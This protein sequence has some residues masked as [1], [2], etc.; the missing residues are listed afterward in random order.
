MANGAEL[1]MILRAEDKNT[2]SVF[3]SVAKE[4]QGMVAGVKSALSG[5]VAIDIMSGVKDG[6]SAIFGGALEAA[7]GVGRLQAQLGLTRQQAEDLGSVA[8]AVFRDG[9]GGSAG[10]VNAAV[11]TVRQNLGDLGSVVTQEMTQAAL[12]VKDLFGA[13]EAE[14]TRTVAVMTKNFQGLSE[15][16]AFDLITAGFQRGGDY[17]GELLDTLREYSPQFASMGM[18]AEQMM[19]VLIAGAQA[20]AFNLDKVG[21]AVKEFNIRAKDGSKATAEGFAAIGLD[22]AKMGA[23]IA[24]G[25]EK[26]QRAFQATIAGLAAMEDPVKRNAAGVALFGTQWEDLESQVI[27]AMA[28]GMQGVEGFRGS[29]AAAAAASAGIGVQWETLK[30]QAMGLLIDG[31]KPLMP[32]F[33]ALASSGIA[34]LQSLLPSMRELGALAIDLGD[35]FSGGDSF[36]AA[37]ERLATA[38]P[39]DV[40]LSIVD[41]VRQIGDAWRTLQQVFGE[42]WEPS[43]EVDPF[44]NAVGQAAVSVKELGTT[45]SDALALARE[46]GAWGAV[47]NGMGNLQ[48]AA[49]EAR[50]RFDE[51]SATFARIGQAAGVAADPVDVLASMIR[52]AALGFE[53]ATTQIA[54]WID[55]TLSG[56]NVVAN[57]A[58]GL[59]Q[60]GTAMRQFAQ[61]DI[62]GMISS[63]EGAGTAFAAGITAAEDYRQRALERTAVQADVTAEMIGG[64][65][66]RIAA[67]TQEDLSQAAVAAETSMAAMVTAVDAAGPAMEAA[68]AAASGAVDAVRAQ[69][70]PAGAAGQSVGDSIGSGLAAGIGAW[71]GSIATRAADLVRT[72]I[73]AARTEADAHSPSRKMVAL[74]Q[75]MAAGL[76]QGLA[77]SGVGEAM[78]GQIRAFIGAASEYAAVAG[79][80]G[81]VEG[82]IAS[83]RER[84]QTDALF[85][86]REMIDVDSESLRLKQAQVS[87]E[88]DLLPLRQDLARAS[89]QIADIERGSL[90]E[91]TG[92]IE[93]D[94]RRKE[95][96]LQQIDLEKQLLGLDSGSKQARGIQEQIDKLREQDRA[97]ALEG[98]RIRLN[99]EIAATGARVRRE[100]LDDQARGQQ[101]V[102]DLIREQLDRLGAEREVFT[103]NEAIIKNATENEIAYRE[104]LIAVF[105]SE[106]EPL[107]ARIA[108]GLRLIDQLEA[109]GAVSK[110]LADQLR[111]V[112]QEASAGSSATKSLGDAAGQAAKSFDGLGEALGDL[113]SWF[114]G[115]TDQALKPEKRASGGPVT[116]GLPYIVGERGPELFVPGGSGRILPSGSFG[117]GGTTVVNVTVQGSLIHEQQ[118][119]A[120]VM[121]AV[122]GGLRRGVGLGVR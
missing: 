73:G 86:A 111:A 121:R 43:A 8:T 103:A 54:G 88:R 66:A 79:Q 72:A 119:E 15:T 5:L 83:V 80:I 118:L 104:R 55:S 57:F 84:A 75:D 21:D 38:L 99:N 97:L 107:A 90:A 1:A 114:E 122:S 4:A 87:M 36:D 67:S 81:R 94:G 22:A 70:G 78:L 37:F 39:E 60:L 13:S 115:A 59:S 64:S 30:R 42:G 16:D 91:R 44:V 18:S 100:Q 19:G 47:Q 20:G 49:T 76:E 113:P 50:D 31:I 14:S 108:E 46:A 27:T 61:G 85:R 68:A 10:E 56:I 120:V 93:M 35:V 29:T 40:A 106:A 24:A 69:Q 34:S 89:Q 92:L 117:D 101:A 116:S 33:T 74:G 3:A 52:G 65:T 17:S 45:I 28:A 32:G 96:R 110:E 63:V 6:V 71:V 23:D 62:A 48:L 7:D 25:G 112:A 95:L 102:I 58:S 11:A 12:T 26:G 98:E 9:F 105:K 82:E 109:E 41:G 53:F 2:A 77:E 51:L